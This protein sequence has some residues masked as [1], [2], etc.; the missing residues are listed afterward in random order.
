MLEIDKLSISFE[1]DSCVVKELSLSISEGET[2]AIVGES[3]SG[4]SS[5]ALAILRLLKR[6]KIKGRILFLGEDL[7]TL[8]DEQLQAIR[9]K[10]IGMIFQDALD[11]LNPTMRIGRQIAEALKKP[12]KEQVIDL[13]NH[14]LVIFPKY[15]YLEFYALV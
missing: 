7:L 14:L 5:V 1:E 12:T 4:K 8:S 9:G 2:V 13:L 10:E 11:A 3:G 6:A 15:H